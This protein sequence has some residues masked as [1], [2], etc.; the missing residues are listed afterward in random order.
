MVYLPELEDLYH[1][2]MPSAKQEDEDDTK[3]G[4][5]NDGGREAKDESGKPKR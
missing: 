1:P 2:L 3:S 5:D 4:R